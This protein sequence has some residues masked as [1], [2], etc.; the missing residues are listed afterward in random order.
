MYGASVKPRG[1]V[2]AVVSVDRSQFG[3]KEDAEEKL[4]P[5]QCSKVSTGDPAGQRRDNFHDCG[6]VDA[7]RVTMDEGCQGNME[8]SIDLGEKF[9]KTCIPRPFDVRDMDL[10]ML[11]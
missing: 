5:I 6:V 10:W 7:E 1:A 4:A 2:N 8:A 3:E 9:L 11:P